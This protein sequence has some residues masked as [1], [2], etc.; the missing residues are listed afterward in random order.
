[1]RKRLAALLV[2]FSWQG[3]SPATAQTPGERTSSNSPNFWH[4]AGGVLALNVVAWSYNRYVQH[5]Q[6][7]N[8]GTR[9][10]WENIRGGFVWD[11]DVFMDNQLAHP[12]HGSLYFNSAR[13]SGYG[14]WQSTPYVT[15]GSLTWELFTENV[16]PSLN[17]FINTTLGGIALGEVTYRLSSALGANRLS[18]RNDF[19]R[20]VG[21]FAL[22][23]IA[24]AQGLLGGRGY[25]R[26]NGGKSW[27]EADMWIAAGRRKATDTPGE[28]SVDRGFVELA[29]QYG[30]PFDPQIARPYDAFDFRL[31]LSPETPGVV[32]HIGVSGLLARK[33]LRE[34]AR[35]Q[36]VF[37]FFQHYDYDDVPVF[38][39]GGQSLSGALLYRRRIGSG[40]QLDLGMHLEGVLLAGMSSDYGHKWRRD[41]DYGS[42]AGTRLA[43]ALRRNRHD[44]IRL[45]G[46]LIWLHSLYGSRADHLAV[47]TRLGTSIRLSGFVGIG[48]DLGVTTRHSWYPDSPA[49]TQRVPQM[50]AYLTW[51]PT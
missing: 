8:V 4:A 43:A 51:R 15:V 38:K 48:C 19:G 45:D 25:D 5:W 20:E 17:D 41:Y 39:S 22:S 31:Q 9:S 27:P 44:V 50:R 7:A 32:T 34:T 30:S 29:V 11:D 33:V 35:S 42:G 24:R 26:E 13:A 37:G 21:A 23:P 1:M 49:V 12:Y 28:N 3:S 47:F 14:F 18:R 6:W 40:T 46:R 36:L 10:W 2:L 16:R